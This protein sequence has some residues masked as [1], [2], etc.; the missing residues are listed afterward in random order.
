MVLKAC[1]KVGNWIFPCCFFVFL[2][3]ACN[4][5]QERNPWD[6]LRFL[7]T[8]A[9]GTKVA[10]LNPSFREPVKY[11]KVMFVSFSQFQRATVVVVSCLLGFFV[12][13]PILHAVLWQLGG[14]RKGVDDVFLSFFLSFLL[15]LREPPLSSTRDWMCISVITSSSKMEFWDQLA[16][17]W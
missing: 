10:Y 1:K 14:W 11:P 4:Q 5:W 15:S 16:D 17:S 12:E 9:V 13:S 3:K 8:K 2:L 6:C 7:T